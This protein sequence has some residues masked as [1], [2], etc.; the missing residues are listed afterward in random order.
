[1][2]TKKFLPSLGLPNE[3]LDGLSVI[4]NVECYENVEKYNSLTN[5]DKFDLFSFH[6]FP[7]APHR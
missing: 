4:S 1:M 5:N 3:S 2:L 7:R 6:S